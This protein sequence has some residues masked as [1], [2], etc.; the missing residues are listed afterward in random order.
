MLLATSAMPRPPIPKACRQVRATFHMS[1]LTFK[2]SLTSCMQ[3]QCSNNKY[4]KYTDHTMARRLDAR[5]TATYGSHPSI[6][7]CIHVCMMTCVRGQHVCM[8]TCVRGQHVCM[9]VWAACLHACV[10]SMLAGGMGSM[11]ACGVGSM[12]ARGV[13]SMLASD[14]GSMFA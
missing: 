13:G 10:G 14:V 3:K 4:N 7:I 1:M 8:M 6:Y 2:S 9:R 11:L 12:F 5:T